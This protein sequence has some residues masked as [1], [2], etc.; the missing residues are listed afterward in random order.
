MAFTISGEL[1][2]VYDS[3]IFEPIKIDDESIYI[4]VI[5]N[6][7]VVHLTHNLNKGEKLKT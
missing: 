6:H 4:I 2:L 3:S 5:V 7:F 1:A